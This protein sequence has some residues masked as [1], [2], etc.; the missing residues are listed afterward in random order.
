MKKGYFLL[1]FALSLAAVSAMVIIANAQMRQRMYDKPWRWEKL[2][3][4]LNLTQEQQ[5][6]FKK[7][8]LDFTR[9][10]IELNANLQIL[11]LDLLE[12]LKDDKIARKDIEKKVDALLEAKN[13]FHKAR[14]DFWLDAR[15]ILTPEQRNAFYDKFVEPMLMSGCWRMGRQ[16]HKQ[17]MMHHMPMSEEEEEEMPMEQE[18]E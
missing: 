13:K 7:L 5:A 17:C 15:E 4:E 14:T 1:A 3:S 16:M 18:E 9:K 11:R 8:W 10:K 12:A 6:K 2:V